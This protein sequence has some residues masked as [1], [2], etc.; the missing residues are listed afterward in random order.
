MLL[1]ITVDTGCMKFLVR[2]DFE[3]EGNIKI[4]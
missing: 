4:K 2:N 3:L 1:N